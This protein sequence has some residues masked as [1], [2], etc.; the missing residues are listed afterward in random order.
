[1]RKIINKNWNWQKVDSKC[2]KRYIFTFTARISKM[3]F[4]HAFK[5]WLSVTYI[6]RGWRAWQRLQ[7][8]AKIHHVRT[9]CSRGKNKSAVNI[10]HHTTNF[11]GEVGRCIVIWHG[12]HRT[13]K[14]SLHVQRYIDVQAIRRRIAVFTICIKGRYD[15]WWNLK[16]V[17]LSR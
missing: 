1:M 8:A 5:Y 2:T 14:V 15:T 12:R 3:I 11:T 17:H 16:A 6:L 4:C 9:C 7:Q 13:I 10:I